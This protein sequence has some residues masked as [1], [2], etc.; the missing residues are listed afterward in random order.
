ML[1]TYIKKQGITQTIVHDNKHNHFNEINWDA[2]YD[3]N[4]ANI[5]VKSNTD[6]KR[7]RFDISLNNEDLADIL[8][9]PSINMPIHKRLKKDFQK[10][11]YGE[12]FLIIEPQ[13]LELPS[14]THQLLSP[15]L[16]SPRILSPEL[17]PRKPEI[18]EQI[19]SNGITTP[20]TNEEF[21]VPLTIDK[22]TM[23]GYIQNPRKKHRRRKTHITHKIYKKPKSMSNSR[24]KSKTHSSRK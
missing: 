17:E 23:D 13:F 16:Q 5:S 8:N 6:G 18:L 14:S 3:G 15:R 4:K 11:S 22:K 20:A 7:D 1:N 19:I 9:I 2:D 10:P 12:P 24:S 21:I